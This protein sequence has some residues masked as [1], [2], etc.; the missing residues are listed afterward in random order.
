M[1]PSAA[2]FG[3]MV[4]EEWSAR[5]AT[6]SS[7]AGSGAQEGICVWVGRL[8]MGSPSLLGRVG[9]LGESGNGVVAEGLRRL[10][11]VP[12]LADVQGVRIVWL[13]VSLVVVDCQVVVLCCQAGSKSLKSP[14]LEEVG[15]G[16]K[17]GIVGV[18]SH[19]A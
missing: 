3:V 19:G 6:V 4:T 7:E 14:L 5:A 12:A 18:G 17:R 16:G 2:L 8:T 9:L 11:A 10:R 13:E 1:Y 15:R